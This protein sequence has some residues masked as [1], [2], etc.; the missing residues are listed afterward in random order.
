MSFK[1]TRWPKTTRTYWWPRIFVARKG[2]REFPDN[3]YVVGLKISSVEPVVT[4]LI[5]LHGL[6]MC[7]LKISREC[8][9]TGFLFWS[10]VQSWSTVT[11]CHRLNEERSIWSWIEQDIIKHRYTSIKKREYIGSSESI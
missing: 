6:R 3:K 5:V 11:F 10:A 4:Y 2:Q 8:Q 7:L 1:A 9:D